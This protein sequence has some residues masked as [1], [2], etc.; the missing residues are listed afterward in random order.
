MFFV[1]QQNMVKAVW[2]APEDR[3]FDTG[4]EIGLTPY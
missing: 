1:T 4:W 3:I 2:H